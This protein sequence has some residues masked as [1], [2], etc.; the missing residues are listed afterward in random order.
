M[1]V[2]MHWAHVS[3]QGPSL[4]SPRKFDRGKNQLIVTGEGLGKAPSTPPAGE[5]H[6]HS[7][8]SHININNAVS[9]AVW[10]TG[11]RLRRG[12]VYSPA[13]GCCL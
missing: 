2:W 4:P 6:L 10:L 11:P 5:R 13:A 1:M 7:L 12:G 8:R 3:A 9:R